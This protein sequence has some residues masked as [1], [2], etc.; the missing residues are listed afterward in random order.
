MVFWKSYFYSKKNKTRRL[1]LKG[2]KLRSLKRPKLRKR[3]KTKKRGGA[4]LYKPGLN[5]VKEK[6]IINI[7]N[8]N[9]SK[10]TKRPQAKPPPKPSTS[11]PAISEFAEHQQL[12][13]A[14]QTKKNRKVAEQ[15]IKNRI[16]AKIKNNSSF[17]FD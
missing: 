16:A 15:E 3:R 2:S 8:K 6:N 1:K 14:V 4:G 11:P 10:V 13:G 9:S 17:D 12:M 5:T 7:N